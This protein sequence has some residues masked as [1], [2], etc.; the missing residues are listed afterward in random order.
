MTSTEKATIAYIKD[1]DD[2]ATEKPY[3]SHVPF[4]VDGQQKWT[5]MV[6]DEHEMLLTDVRGKEKDYTLDLNGFSYVRY[7]AKNKPSDAIKSPDHP[8]VVEMAAWLKDL[9]H[10]R[11][12]FVY[13]CNIRK[14]GQAEFFGAATHAHVDH[15]KSNSIL[16]LQNLLTTLGLQEE[17]IKRYQIV[18]TWAPINGAVTDSPLAVCDFQSAQDEDLV[19]VD[20]VF[21]HQ[22]MEIYHVKHNAS[23]KWNYLCNQNNDEVLLLKTY[24]SKEGVASHCIHTAVSFLDLH[25]L[26]RES[27]ELRSIVVY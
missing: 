15:S 26:K 5:N 17:N 16:R 25:E 14:C 7:V 13:D 2:F 22:V 23:H 9:L 27:V 18:N 24:D 8:Y 4:T 1:D 12:V 19:A 10:A 11:H 6:F 3:M 21:P 20:V